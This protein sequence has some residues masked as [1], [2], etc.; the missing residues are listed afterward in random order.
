MVEKE[1]HFQPT[2]EIRG[3]SVH[4]LTPPIAFTPDLAPQISAWPVDTRTFAGLNHSSCS[5]CSDEPSDWPL[6]WAEAKNQSQT[7]RQGVLNWNAKWMLNVGPE[8][9]SQEWA[10]FQFENASQNLS[11]PSPWATLEFYFSFSVQSHIFGSSEQ[12]LMK[13]QHL[14][15]HL[16]GS[17]LESPYI[18]TG[19]FSK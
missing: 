18:H 6:S 3:L 13:I 19:N 12:R 2:W 14:W 10:A 16:P 8:G 1:K 7:C 9:N 5:W 4:D 11:L 15:K 17:S